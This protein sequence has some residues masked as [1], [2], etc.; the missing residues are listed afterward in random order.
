MV[1]GSCTAGLQEEG[2]CITG[3]I[4]NILIDHH[5]IELTITYEK[6]EVFD[7]NSANSFML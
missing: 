7:F 6:I 1:D 4:K 5:I 3:V 2:T